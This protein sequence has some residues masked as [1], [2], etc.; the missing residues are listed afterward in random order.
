MN[1]RVR[2]HSVLALLM[3]A[4]CSSLRRRPSRTSA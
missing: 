3:L 2:V 1:V 4:N